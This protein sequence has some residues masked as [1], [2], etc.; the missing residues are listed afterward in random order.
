MKYKV[1]KFH[2]S[3]LKE[4]YYWEFKPFYDTLPDELEAPEYSEHI[5]TKTMTHKE[6][7]ETYEKK[8]FTM[9]EAFAV[10]ANYASKAKNGQWRIVYF[11]Y[12]DVPCWLNV[13]REDGGF[14][15]L[16][17]VKVDLDSTWHAGS[18]VLVSNENLDTVSSN[19]DTLSL[20]SLDARLSKV[21]EV[22]S[23][24]KSL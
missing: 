7:M 14:L 9:E 3:I 12:G 23:K 15:N 19:S 16:A 5:F 10:A 22:V 1:T 18:G 21:E 6:I 17:V 11:R 8:P 4:G 2:K 13:W 20:G 24:L